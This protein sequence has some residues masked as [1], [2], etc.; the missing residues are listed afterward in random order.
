MS[1]SRQP[2]FREHL[3]K[4]IAGFFWLAAGLFVLLSLVSFDNSD[5]SFNNNLRPEVVSNIGGKVGAYLADLFYQ[6]F[7]LPAVLVPLA[8]LLLSWR[9]LKFRDIK[10]PLYKIAA[11]LIMLISLAGLIALWVREFSLAGRVVKQAGGAVGRLL[12]ETLTSYLNVTG[13]AIFLT[14]F[15]V[16]SLMLTARF[17]FVLFLEGILSRL[18]GHFASVREAQTARKV[19]QARKT[20]DRLDATPLIALPEPKSTTFTPKGEKTKKKNGEEPAQ[21]VFEVLEATGTYH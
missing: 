13:A 19:H 17:S 8:C 4:E 16:V 3:K 1:D 7:G 15:L 18:S 10:L 20:G 14:V 6:V 12:V 5:P 11:F 2:F 21:E 9:L